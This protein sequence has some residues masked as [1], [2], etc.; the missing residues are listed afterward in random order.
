[1]SYGF[2]TSRFT[3]VFDASNQITNFAGAEFVDRCRHWS[4]HAHFKCFVHSVSLHKSQLLGAAHTTIHYAHRRNNAAILVVLTIKNQS[5]QRC[6]GI[7]SRSRNFLDDCIE[8][9]RHAVASF[10]RDA[11]NIFGANAENFFDL[12]RI[13]IWVGS[14]QINFVKCSDDFE[15]V[16]KRQITVRQCL[17]FDALCR[18]NN[19]NNTFARRQRPTHFITKVDM[20]W[21]VD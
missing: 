7:T 8:Q 18:I 10:G 12:H 1:M 20:P 14:R 5:L 3:H 17:R 21:C 15:I 19:Q 13:S 9:L 11:Q 16:F 4:S 6:I 2:T